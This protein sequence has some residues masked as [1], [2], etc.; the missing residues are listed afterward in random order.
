MK[1]E[2]LTFF[3][4]ARS[5]PVRVVAAPHFHVTNPVVEP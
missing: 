2:A 1:K 5:T 3:L 4:R